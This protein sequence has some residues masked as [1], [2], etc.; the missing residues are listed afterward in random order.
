MRGKLEFSSAAVES[1]KPNLNFAKNILDVKLYRDPNSQAIFIGFDLITKSCKNFTKLP[2]NLQQHIA[3]TP[4]NEE[5]I[6]KI[7]W[8][9]AS[10]EEKTFLSSDYV[11]GQVFDKKSQLNFAKNS[12]YYQLPTN[13][14]AA[15]NWLGAFILYLNQDASRFCMHFKDYS[16]DTNDENFYQ[17]VTEIDCINNYQTENK[18]NNTVHRLLIEAIL[19]FKNDNSSDSYVDAMQVIETVYKNYCADREK[20]LIVNFLGYVN[21]SAYLQLKHQLA[22][23]NLLTTVI[24]KPAH[25][26][27]KYKWNYVEINFLLAANFSMTQDGKLCIVGLEKNPSYEKY[28]APGQRLEQIFEPEL[29]YLADKLGLAFDKDNFK[30][31]G[32]IFNME[33]T[34]KLVNGYGIVCLE[35]F[36][37]DGFAILAQPVKKFEIQFNSPISIELPEEIQKQLTAIKSCVQMIQRKNGIES[38]NATF[39]LNSNE[40]TLVLFNGRNGYNTDEIDS[41]NKKVIKLLSALGAKISKEPYHFSYWSQSTATLPYQ[42]I[43]NVINALALEAD[44]PMIDRMV[45]TC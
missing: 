12:I 38:V 19:S 6:L 13:P 9:E 30:E 21:P 10:E 43:D 35:A 14:K 45:A 33:S 31:N 23:K 25:D 44:I 36:K 41:E 16:S 11:S 32:L 40:V 27:G 5:K 42:K 20:N 26:G 2:L 22:I 3:I 34:Q 17:G 4:T 37:Q 28:Y 24:N 15:L 18:V 29:H 1:K 39:D 7:I 8:E